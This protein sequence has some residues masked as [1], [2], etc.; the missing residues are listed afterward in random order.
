MLEV[1]A[2]N[3]A[4]WQSILKPDTFALLQRQ[5]D[6]RNQDTDNDVWRGDAI[7]EFLFNNC[8]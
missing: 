7:T 5:A 6:E 3:L 8:K 1:Q 4:F 2:S